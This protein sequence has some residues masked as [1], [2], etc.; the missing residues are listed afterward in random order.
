MKNLKTVL[1]AAPLI[2]LSQILFC[3][4]HYIVTPHNIYATVEEITA[5]YNTP[6]QVSSDLIA[7]HLEIAIRADTY[8]ES[9]QRPELSFE[10]ANENTVNLSW[11]EVP[12]SKS[13]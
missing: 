10:G 6:I 13:L 12:G 1:M 9:C 3:Q 11:P 4:G 5:T 2:L 8:N 7:D